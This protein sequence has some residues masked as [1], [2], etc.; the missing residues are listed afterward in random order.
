LVIFTTWRESQGGRY[1]RAALAIQGITVDEKTSWSM[2]PFKRSAGLF[3]HGGNAGIGQIPRRQYLPESQ[4]AEPL[5]RAL[6]GPTL[7]AIS[8][9]SERGLAPIVRFDGNAWAMICGPP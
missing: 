1:E 7:S 6:P 3:R 2:A 5:G 4:F 8:P 9:F